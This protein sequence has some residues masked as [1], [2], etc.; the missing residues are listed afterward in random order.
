MALLKRIVAIIGA[1]ALTFVALPGQATPLINTKYVE[2]ADAAAAMYNPLVVNQFNLTMPQSTID[3]LNGTTNYWGN[4][5]PY[6]PAKLGGTV[7]GVAFG[8]MDVGVHLKGAWGSWRNI[9]GKAGFKVKI[10][11]KDKTQNLYGVT[12]LTLNNMVQD[13][14][15]LHETMAYRLFRALDVPTARTGYA[16][17]S[18][19][20]QNYGLHLNIETFD[21]KLLKRWGI[22]PIHIYKGG[23]PNF[24]DLWPGEEWK[25]AIEQGST[26]DKSDLTALMAVVGRGNGVNWFRDMNAVADLKEMTLDWA[27]EKFTG[28]WDG[29]VQN[30]NNFY[31]VKRPDGKFIMLPWGMD[32]T[33][34]GAIDYWGG[35][36]MLNQCINDAQ[37]LALY[38][39]AIV[40][41]V[42][43]AQDLDLTQLSLDTA[44]AINPSLLADPKKEF[45]NNYIPDV[46]APSRWFITGQVQNGLAMVASYDAN[47]KS[48]G[49]VGQP[50]VAARQTLSVSNETKTIR[51]TGAPSS[52]NSWSPQTEA[53]PLVVGLNELPIVVTNSVGH[54]SKT[55][56]VKVYRMALFTKTTN[57]SATGNGTALSSPAIKAINALGALAA[58]SSNQTL[59]IKMQSPAGMNSKNSGNLLKA[60]ALRLQTLLAASG[61]Y[62]SKVSL[63][64]TTVKG[65]NT[66]AITLSYQR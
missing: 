66:L 31:L 1:M 39:Q 60:R 24:P 2:G 42:H 14:S 43:T 62:P 35:S 33:W 57:I 59:V 54:V 3:G 29:Y 8:P 64:V 36:A 16:N 25:Y 46:Q 20:G 15:S 49:L 45:S 38:K 10:N 63:V 17:V 27:A 18:V 30:H 21:T 13:A 56:M 48:F 37:C 7:N 9:Y 28:H 12:K 58:Q 5:G 53:Q 51:L 50:A 34:N 23:V 61:V 52:V 6:L 44:A 19:N 55:T 26:T 4:E 11:F 40:Q 32:Q 22:E 65:P 47:L 41:V